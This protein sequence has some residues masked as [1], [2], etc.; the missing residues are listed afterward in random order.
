M[1]IIEVVVDPRLGPIMYEAQ[2]LGDM[3]MMV[4]C[5]GRQRDENDWR[6]I[7]AKAGFSDHRIVKKIG[8]RGVIEVYP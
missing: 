1:I 8:V 4:N 3:C 7:F 6:D 2:L 5:R